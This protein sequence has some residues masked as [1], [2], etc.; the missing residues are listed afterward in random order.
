MQE[1]PD[2]RAIARFFFLLY[3]T[4]Q[5]M[6]LRNI[7]ELLP[8]LQAHL[9]LGSMAGSLLDKVEGERPLARQSAVLLALFEQEGMTHL[10]FIRRSMLLRAHGG[11]I[12]FPGGS[13]ETGDGSLV[14]TAL[15]EAQEEIGLLPTRVE[16]L[17]LLDP[18]FTVVSNFLIVPVVA[19]LPKGPGV[20][21]RQTAEVDEILRLPL[22]GLA[23]PA[24][25]HTEIWT[26]ERYSR[27]VYF[28]DYGALRIWGATAR[29]LH[30]LLELLA[31]AS[32]VPPQR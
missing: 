31:S 1:V 11:E 25:A 20:L 10:I 2:D 28:Y 29:I 18:V 24:I 9:H 23:E 8:A 13:F 32:S 27:T 16:V 4:M 17:G 12:A 7:S 19:Y 6:D 30:G 15:R 14:T 3:A 22:P 5:S 26:R 21:E